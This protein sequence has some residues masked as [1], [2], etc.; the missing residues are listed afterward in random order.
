MS[1]MDCR[2][3]LPCVQLSVQLH[4]TCVKLLK[5]LMLWRL[6]DVL[7]HEDKE[8]NIPK[9]VVVK[10]QKGPETAFDIWLCTWNDSLYVAIEPEL[11]FS[12]FPVAGNSPSEEPSEISEES[13]NKNKVINEEY[14]VWKK[15]APFLYD[16]MMRSVMDNLQPCSNSRDTIVG[17]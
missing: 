14:K 12:V 5:T 6:L 3:S 2:Y 8:T 4:R 17:R 11:T 13:I 7:S 15:H 9:V 10:F 16:V 1:E